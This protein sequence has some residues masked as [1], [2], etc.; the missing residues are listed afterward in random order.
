LMISCFASTD[1]ERRTNNILRKNKK[2]PF[3]TFLFVYICFLFGSELCCF[4]CNKNN[5]L[6]EGIEMLFTSFLA[7][8]E[9][10]ESFINFL[11][12]YETLLLSV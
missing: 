11:S 9:S 4:R 12:D 2:K 5:K 3:W 8:I 7:N 10:K 6:V 1:F